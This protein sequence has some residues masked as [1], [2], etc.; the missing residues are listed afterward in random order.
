MLTSFWVDCTR[1]SPVFVAGFT[2]A[3]DPP[4]LAERLRT[5]LHQAGPRQEVIALVTVV[6]A[7]ETAGLPCPLWAQLR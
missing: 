4:R 2:V 5:C 7:A 6:V 3:I 1:V